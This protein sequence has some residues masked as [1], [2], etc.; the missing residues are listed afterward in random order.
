MKLLTNA[1]IWHNGTF[2]DF[3][4]LINGAKIEALLPAAFIPG[5]E[6][7]VIDL[8]KGY[9]YPG[10]IDT[11]T[12]SFEGGLYSLGVDL[13]S[14]K[15]IPE[16]LALLDGAY[17]KDDGSSLIFAWQFDETSIPEQRFP[18]LAELDSVC[19]HRALVLRRIDGHS[20]ILNSF[21]RQL[22]PR[23]PSS[24]EIYRGGD[25]DQAVHFFHKSLSD[26]VVLNAYQHAAA[27]ALKGGFTGIHTMVGDADQSINHLPLLMANLQ[28]F[29]ITY[30]LYP[31]SFNLHAALEI[32]SPRIGGCILADGSI[33]SET[34][35]LS[36]PYLGK[37]TSGY[38]CHSDDF[39][40]SFITKAHQH[41]MQVAVHCIGDAAIAQINNIYRE[42]QDSDP[43]DLRHQLI[44]CE[45]TPD[46]LIEDI[47]A[48]QAV[49]VMQ[50][51]FD[52]LWG[53]DEGFYSRK[54]GLQ[55]S[56]QMNRLATFARHEVRITGG[57]DWY[58]TALDAAMSI[59]AAMR[60]HHP[61][62]RLSHAQ[63]VDIYT[64]NAA[65]LSHNE[66]TKGRIATGYDADLTVYSHAL[67]DFA[68]DPQ[69]LQVYTNGECRYYAQ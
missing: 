13:S 44:H 68:N 47:A 34:A 62:E 3:S 64:T 6:V 46:W 19:P 59:R 55:R 23:L 11:H 69:V 41:N 18:T 38:L 28:Q 10:F 53:G 39:W 32:A 58:I 65:W 52:L 56:R 12:H 24:D 7:Q 51:N 66:Q 9:V 42:L 40:R 48:S 37:T 31:Q 20:C 63:S 5:S 26:E 36:S 14:V 21:A 61:A 60:H 27:I 49:P 15:S 50:P 25:N 8:H 22:L 16:V 54:L 33:G 30:T 43:K 2:K 1:K 29:P 35:A 45:I 17:H 67:D 4:L 57:S